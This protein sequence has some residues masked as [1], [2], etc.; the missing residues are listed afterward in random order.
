M[1]IFT[2]F[3]TNIFAKDILNEPSFVLLFYFATSTL[4][5]LSL[6]FGK[7]I[8]LTECITLSHKIYICELP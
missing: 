3:K 8:F 6:F 1:N 2:H 4:K 7:Y 5:S